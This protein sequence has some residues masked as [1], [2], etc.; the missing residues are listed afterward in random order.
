ETDSGEVT[1]CHLHNMNL[2]FVKPQWRDFVSDVRGPWFKGL[3]EH[4]KVIAVA[5]SF[6]CPQQLRVKASKKGYWKVLERIMG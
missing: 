2:P 4:D 6:M 5:D 3:Y 1:E